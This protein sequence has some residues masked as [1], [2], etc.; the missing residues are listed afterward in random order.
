MIDHLA[1]AENALL[2]IFTAECAVLEHRQLSNLRYQAST[3][4]CLYPLIFC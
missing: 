2:T 4:V 1:W 3:S